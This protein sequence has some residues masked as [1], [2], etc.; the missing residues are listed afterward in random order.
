MN[1]TNFTQQVLW[2]IILLN[3]PVVLFSQ[4]ERK[5]PIEISDINLPSELDEPQILLSAIV[6]DEDSYVLT[7][8]IEN[9]AEFRKEMIVR[10]FTEDNFIYALRKGRSQLLD[11]LQRQQGQNNLSPR[12]AK[13]IP[14]QKS[15]S[16]SM[17]S[18]FTQYETG[19][20]YQFKG[21]EIATP[22]GF[23]KPIAGKLYFSSEV[24]VKKKLNAFDEK[25]A[26]INE[27][28]TINDKWKK[29]LASAGLPDTE[30]K[31][32]S[33]G[34]SL[35]EQAQLE[36]IRK[37]DGLFEE[38][39]EQVLVNL[40]GVLSLHSRIE[41]EKDS[42]NNKFREFSKL[43][44]DDTSLVQNL[45]DRF[46]QEMESAYKS[47][48]YPIWNRGGEDRKKIEAD[49]E[50]KE[51]ERIMMQNYENGIESNVNEFRI[52]VWN[53]QGK[54]HRI[55]TSDIPYLRKS[56][57]ELD[58]LYSSL[59]P[60]LSTK[61]S[62]TFKLEYAE[63]EFNEGFIENILVVGDVKTLN[64]GKFYNNR[65][66][67]NLIDTKD[68]NATLDELGYFSKRIKFES[69]YPYGFSRKSDYEALSKI[70]ITSNGKN[71]EDRYTLELGDLLSIYLPKH[72][73]GRR[74]FSPENKVIQY[75]P[76]TEGKDYVTLYKEETS[77]IFEARVYSDFVGLDSKAANGLLQ[78]EIAKRLNLNTKRPILNCGN[79]LRGFG[80]FAWLEPTITLSKIEQNN[81]NLLL[82]EIVPND[83]FG[84]N[85]YYATSLDVRRHESLSVGARLNILSY[86]IPSL[87]STISGNGALYYGRTP[88][89]TD[90]MESGINTLTFLPELNC[91]VRADERW[92]LSFSYRWNFM[93]T[94]SR[95]VVQIS[96][97]LDPDNKLAKGIKN[98]QY[99]TAQFQVFFQPSEDNRGRLFFRYRYHWQYGDQNLGFHQAQVGYSFYLLGRNKGKEKP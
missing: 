78:T 62:F 49:P 67:F 77:K 1:K 33:V 3:L 31:S 29:Y 20:F 86:D 88:I 90:T 74:D 46:L 16:D 10:P 30:K 91:D 8:R 79:F 89:Q 25:V 53:A 2:F 95:E 11:Q 5:Y 75:Y 65:T 37:D 87:K 92:G 71:D 43:V 58:S 54:W 72:E 82:S 73:V 69:K 38:T 15:V 22:V 96:D 64:L 98:K 41:R 55:N 56:E 17:D 7:F 63:I 36:K 19:L 97:L 45:K 76:A 81:K 39:R 66:L 50:L 48:S 13:R 6:K 51:I 21:S 23:G 61:T 9:N 32:K 57:K 42:L 68:A 60:A 70:K 28:K 47:R 80:T 85:R 18:S 24:I 12:R 59:I 27:E 94:L 52:F 4:N 14:H 34:K 35:K 40:K 44:K 99:N 93:R 84:R 26:N 83:T